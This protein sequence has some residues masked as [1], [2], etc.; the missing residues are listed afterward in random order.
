MQI[1]LG[2]TNYFFHNGREEQVTK[3]RE[4][5][6]IWLTEEYEK[7]EFRYTWTTTMEM[8]IVVLVT[9]EVIFSAVQYFSPS[10]K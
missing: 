2:S 6:L 1:C 7:S 4:D 9:A 5:L 8:A 10:G 3:H